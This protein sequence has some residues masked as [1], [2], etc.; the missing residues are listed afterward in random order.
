MVDTAACTARETGRVVET[1]SASTCRDTASVV[2][3][4]TPTTRDTA[5][6]VDTGDVG[7]TSSTD[8][9]RDCGV[10]DC[11]AHEVT[12]AFVSHQRRSVLLVR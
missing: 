10:M 9:A 12:A 11:A 7:T 8:T 3:T 2:A 4:S 5:R 1:V 6:V